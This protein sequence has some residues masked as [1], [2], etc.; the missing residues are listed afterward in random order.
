M[1][2]I[3]DD[4]FHMKWVNECAKG[5]FTLMDFKPMRLIGSGDSENDDCSL[6]VLA[7]VWSGRCVSSEAN[8]YNNLIKKRL[9]THNVRDS[10]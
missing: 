8:D 1:A 10:R 5:R 7:Q 9:L 6:L 4:F 2:E 3:K